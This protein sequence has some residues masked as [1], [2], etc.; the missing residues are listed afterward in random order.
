MVRMTH[1]DL[2]YNTDLEICDPKKDY[3]GKLKKTERWENS[4]FSFE[5]QNALILRSA[6]KSVAPDHLIQSISSS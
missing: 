4:R 5:M 1:G 3:G 6:T 2:F